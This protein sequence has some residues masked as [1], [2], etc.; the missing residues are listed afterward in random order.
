M[1]RSA[2]LVYSILLVTIPADG[3]KTPD[4]KISLRGTFLS[5]ESYYYTVFKVTQYFQ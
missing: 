3:I 1:A 5:I 4:S 2:N